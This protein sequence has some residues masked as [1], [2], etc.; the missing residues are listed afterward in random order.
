MEKNIGPTV[1]TPVTIKSHKVTYDIIAYRGL[2]EQEAKAAISFY[3]KDHQKPS[4]GQRIKIVTVFG[5]SD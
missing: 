2:S 5:H 4:P 1:V 3:L